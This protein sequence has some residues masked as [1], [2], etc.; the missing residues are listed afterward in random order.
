MTTGRRR[1]KFKLILNQKE[2]LIRWL[3]N[4]EAQATFTGRRA[5]RQKFR[6]ELEEEKIGEVL[7]YPEPWPRSGIH[8]R[9]YDGRHSSDC[10]F[11][12]FTRQVR[13]WCKR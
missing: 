8:V 4:D 7:T 10:I 6:R 5:P 2:S 13:Q 11:D 3:A 1:Q 12:G 9:R